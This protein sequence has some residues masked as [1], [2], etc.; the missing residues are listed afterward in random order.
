MEKT[1]HREYKLWMEY[2]NEEWKTLKLSD[3]YLMQIAQEVQRVL[4]KNP[5]KIKLLQ[6]ELPFDSDKPKSKKLTE[7]EKKN[8]TRGVI[9]GWWGM[10]TGK[11]R[12]KNG[13]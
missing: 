2:F 9:A 4:S 6:F 7:L 8:K 10:V 1:S 12:K 13:Q 11:P 3:Y 5:N